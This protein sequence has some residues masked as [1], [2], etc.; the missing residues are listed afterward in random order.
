NVTDGTHDSN[1]GGYG[2][3][4]TVNPATYA[5]LRITGTASMTAGT[6]NELT[7]Q[8]RDAY[9][10]VATSYTGTKSL[11]FS[12]PGVSV[13]GFTA[14]VE[15][16]NVGTGTSINFTSGISDSNVATLI[17]YKAESTTVNVTDGTHD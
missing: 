7:I 5:S 16:T 14:T 13:D 15:G 3:S 11:T 4:L 12:G 10:N 6:T 8:A 1:T 9:G 17:A 2:L